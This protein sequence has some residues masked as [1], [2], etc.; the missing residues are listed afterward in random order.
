MNKTTAKKP[1][2]GE[3]CVLVSETGS[4]DGRKYFFHQI[5]ESGDGAKVGCGCET[6][7]ISWRAKEALFA[8]RA[9][10]VKDAAEFIEEILREISV[11]ELLNIPCLHIIP[12]NSTI[13]ADGKY[14]IKGE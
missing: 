6:Y 3:P 11:A 13:T 2:A 12:E 7:P 8:L 14:L 9:G 1:Q 10:S 4:D 5:F